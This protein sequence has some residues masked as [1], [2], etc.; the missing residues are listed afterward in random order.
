MHRVK[1]IVLLISILV[2]S[3]AKLFSQVSVT[4]S[5]ANNL[6][7][8]KV[9]LDGIPDWQDY[10]KVKLWYA[11]Y[12]RDPVLAQVQVIIALQSTSSGG[13]LYHL[14]FIG[15]ENFIGN[16]DT[17]TYTAPLEN[18]KRE[19]RDEL[20]NVIAMG[21]MYYFSMNGQQK[22]F[23]FDYNDALGKINKSSDKW[24]YWVFTAQTSPDLTV[25]QGGTAL[26][27]S[28][29]ISAAHITD[30]WKFRI[31]GDAVIDYSKFTTDTVNYESTE[32]IRHLNVLLVKS[33]NDHWSWGIEAGYYASSFS[34]VQSQFSFAPGFEY[35]IFPYSE[36]VNHILTFKYRLKPLYN[37]YIDSTIYD[38]E[39]E[40]L[41]NQIF[42]ATY[43]RIER[44]GNFS[45]TLTATQYLNHLDQFRFDITGQMDFHLAKGLFLN[46]G[47]NFSYIKNQR[48]LSNVD[49]T[50]EEIILQHKE[51]LTN[52]SYGLQIGIT[53]TFGAIYNNIVNPRYESG[54]TIDPEV[55]DI[56][57]ST[58]GD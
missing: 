13:D 35:D 12:V 36:S 54:I 52:Y 56:L 18:T 17:L 24:N 43:T 26:S 11:D 51:I 15:R 58:G 50:P 19:T 16:N 25:D 44:W 8:L 46:L 41:L 1:L 38:K 53:Y 33:I 9:Y 47:G 30:E 49:L 2:F 32:L 21:L 34:N 5:T 45:T 10:V 6:K 48:T 27:G 39:Q 37:F 57:D 55:T 31:L 42:D 22:Y 14:F 20:T 29:S 28:A 3:F 7:H 40:F 23:I 4:D